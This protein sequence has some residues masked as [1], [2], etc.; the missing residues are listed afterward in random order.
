MLLSLD[1]R[2]HLFDVVEAPDQARAQIEAG[3]AKRGPRLRV[4]ELIESRPE[5]VVHDA[6]ERLPSLASQLFETR[7]HVFFQRQCGAHN[8]MP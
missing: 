1:A 4:V 5:R 3:G 7:R 2:E 6:L 8:L